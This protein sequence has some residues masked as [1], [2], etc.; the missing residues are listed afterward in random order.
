MDAPTA[1]PPQHPQG[2]SKAGTARPSSPISVFGEDF[3][4]LIRAP[5]RMRIA[6]SVIRVLS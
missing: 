1:K 6:R 2:L 5:R 3:S 4:L